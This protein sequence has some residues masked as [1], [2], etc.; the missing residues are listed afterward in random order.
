MRFPDEEYTAIR[1]FADLGG[2]KDR[3]V[4][5]AVASRSLL[6]LSGK[7][8]LRSVGPAGPGRAACCKDRFDLSCFFA[9][10]LR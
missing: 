1:K 4:V 2:M 8:L 6:L 10:L 3:D 9:R 7:N 5:V